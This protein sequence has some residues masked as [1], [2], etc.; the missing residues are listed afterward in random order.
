MEKKFDPL[1]LF[2]FSRFS[3]SPSLVDAADGRRP[4]RNDSIISR[5][6]AENAAVSGVVTVRNDLASR[7]FEGRTVDKRRV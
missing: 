3:K 2:S 5:K 6:F 4:F 1:N 7:V